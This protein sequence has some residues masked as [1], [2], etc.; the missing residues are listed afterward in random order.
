MF[1]KRPVRDSPDF[2]RIQALPVRDPDNYPP[3]LVE[4]LTQELKQ[5]GGVE[6][7]LPKQAEALYD[8]LKYR[9]GFFP[10]RVG[11]GKTL[12]SF[13]APVVL[14]AKRPRLI[15]PAKLVEETK[16]KLRD[17]LKNW[18]SARHLDMMSYEGLGRVS[19]ADKLDRE[20]PDLLILDEGHKAK[21]PR[22][23][24][25]RR[26][27]RYIKNNPECIVVVLSGTIMKGSIKN[28]AHLQSWTHHE[29]S[30][31]PLYAETLTEWS[32]ALDENVSSLSQRDPGVLLDLYPNV[33]YLDNGGDG[34]DNNRRA[35]R[36]FYARARATPGVVISDNVEDF[37]GSLVI[38]G[39]EYAVNAK[40]DAN[41]KLLREE[42]CR[43]DGWALAEAMHV[44]AEARRLSIG[45]HYEWSPKPPDE[46]LQSRRDW[47]KFVRDFLAKPSSVARGFDSELQVANGVLNGD[48]DD[49]YGILE[50]WRRLKPTFQINPIDV[51]HD[52]SA[53]NL[54]A[55]W[56]AN[57]SR[58]ICWVEHVFFGKELSRRTGIP[59]YG[60]GGLDKHGNR[61]QEQA[62]V[63]HPG[64]IIA[65]V[66]AN[67]E[68][69]NLQHNWCDNLVTASLKDSE[70]WEQLIA[71]THR[72]W[73]TEDTVTVDVLVGCREHLQ[74][75][76][77]ALSSA[78]VKKDLLGF[79]QKVDI[80]DKIWPDLNV[81][82]V[83]FR[84]V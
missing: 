28:F 55:D 9:K 57:H 32:E 53:L 31:L 10:L 1:G 59:Y 5:P 2:R 48:I 14:G 47:A 71:R 33:A 35:R 17:S 63:P 29:S 45:L 22:A 64:P 39:L 7:L 56:L 69:R 40:T 41:F 58:G 25:T 23:A 43:P 82:R 80:A 70:R 26:L 18:K 73:Q 12:I 60:A 42:M 27:G 38:T 8:L 75:I 74:S 30:I 51:W 4:F 68:G 34:D 24:V 79:T 76:P 6:T 16:H 37:T 61:I 52:D 83:G 78:E 65:S 49:P 36:T 62:V 54:C 21:N 77:K 67:A 3:G 81:K 44:W 66:A 11:A 15:L 20:K 46:W 13:L 72:K 19:G 84:W 50:E